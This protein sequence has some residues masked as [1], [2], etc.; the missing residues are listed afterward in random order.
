MHSQVIK[1]VN[2]PPF[3]PEDAVAAGL[4]TGAKQKLDAMHNIHH[5]VHADSFGQDGASSSRKGLQTS[6]LQ[7]A[8]ADMVTKASASV[9]AGQSGPADA[10]S[11]TTSSSGVPAHTPFL[12]QNAADKAA[13]LGQLTVNVPGHRQ[14]ADM[15]TTCNVSQSFHRLAAQ[16]CKIT[17]NAK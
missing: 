5:F 13:L 14:P 7:S 17:P 1:Y 6:D 4:I 8:G 10:A 16:V 3:Y 11:D 2:M 15:N 9:E 12:L